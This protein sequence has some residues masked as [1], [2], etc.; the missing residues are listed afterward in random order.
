M[1]RKRKV[2]LFRKFRYK[3]G[4]FILFTPAALAM[5]NNF[6]R[7][8]DSW[9]T[10]AILSFKLGGKELSKLAAHSDHSKYP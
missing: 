7:V 9:P 3:N 8:G 10:C 4:S 6:D 2:V 1:F 5:R